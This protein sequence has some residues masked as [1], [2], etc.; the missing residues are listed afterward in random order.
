MWI[1]RAKWQQLRESINDVQSDLLQVSC[2]QTRQGEW[3]ELVTD[4]S[5]EKIAAEFGR[6]LQDKMSDGHK[7]T[8]VMLVELNKQAVTNVCG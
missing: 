1:S 4:I 5:A 2:R 7:I 8:N 3:L 6:L